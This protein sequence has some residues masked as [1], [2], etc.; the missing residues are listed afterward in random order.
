MS[1]RIATLWLALQLA[2]GPP[3][4]AFTGNTGG[5]T[6]Q[7]LRIGAGARALGM[8]EAYGPVAEGPD[9]V[10]WN[11]AGLAQLSR[12]EASYSHIEM[13]RYFHHEHA[14]YAHPV[15]RL[16]GTAAVSLT[17]FYQD[18]LD[19][20]TNTNQTI[21]S[22]SSHS[23]AFTFA[24]AR[25]FAVGA[26]MLTRN[27]R[28]FQDLWRVRY[29]E[30]P[31]QFEDE[32][33]QGSLMAGAAL[34]VVRE[35][36]YRHSAVAVAVDG[37]VLF[38]HEDLPGAALSFSFRNV[39]S[40]PR[41]VRKAESLPAEID[42]GAAYD[43]RLGDHRLVTALVAAVPYH[44]DPVG[45]LGVEYSVRV[46]D[47]YGAAVRAGYKSLTAADLGPLTGLTGGVGLRIRRMTFDVGFQ[48]MAVL[49]EVFRGTVGYRF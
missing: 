36:I 34:K 33:W 2:A 15:P 11:P 49:G 32:L 48:P 21:G 17:L 30:L 7:F 12:P 39:G 25:D 19:L 42:F 47:D 4:R 28:D 46:G 35:T 10:Y 18:S 41:F 3:A 9:A 27:R 20:V 6:A 5:S 38:R 31:L 24:Y 23:E 37:G 16:G 8:G 44:G 26:D 13:L 43:L 40:R 22:F 29:A 1:A 45:K 14:A